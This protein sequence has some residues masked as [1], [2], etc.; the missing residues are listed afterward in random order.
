[1]FERLSV[2]AS[3]IRALFLK[4]SLDRDFNEELQSHLAMLIDENLRRGLSPPE[5]RRQALL[6]LGGPSQIEEANREQRGLPQIDT[7]LQDLRYGLRTLAANRAFTVVAVATLALGIG[8]NTMI[9]SVVNAVFLKPPPYRDPDRLVNVWQT[10]ARHPGERS[11][12]SAPN[13]LDWR[14][15]NHVFESM[16]MFDSAGRGYNLSGEKEPERVYGL[17]VTA[18]LFPLLG[19][20]PFLGRTFLPEEEIRGRDRVVVLAYGLWLRRYGADRSLVGKTIRVDGEP[21]TVVGVMPP[22]FEFDFFSE[23]N[24]LW[25]PVGLDSGDRQRGAHSFGACA[26]LKPGVSLAQ[27]RAE[28]DTIGHRLAR[29]FPQDNG[30]GSVGVTPMYELGVN[31]LR[32]TFTVLFTV[33]GFV[34]LIA[35]VNVANLTLAR[36][37]ARQ[38]ELAIRRALG[39]GRLRIVRQLL[40][41]SLLLALIGGTAGLA[42]ASGGIRLLERVL[43]DDLRYIPFRHLDRISMDGGVFVFTLLVCCITGILFGLASAISALRTGVNEPLKDGASRAS[44]DRLGD[45]L[46]HVL[47]ASEVTLALIV[48]AGAGLL[49]DSMIR[50]LGI[51]PGLDPK[52]VLTMSVSLP[53]TVLYYSPPVRADFCRELSTRAGAIPGVLSVSSI[54]HLPLSGSGAGRGFVIEGRPDPGV[55]DEPGAGYSVTCPAYLKTM[56]IPLLAGREFNDQDTVGA[57]GVIIINQAMARRDWPKENPIGKRIKL[58]HYSS[59]APWLTVVGVAGDVRHFGL[60]EEIRPWFCRPYTQAAWPFMSIVVRTASAPLSF[61]RPVA[62]ALAEFDP[63]QAASSVQTMEEVVR[64]SLGPRRLPMFLLA[65]FGLLA[66]ILAAVGISGV[67]GYSVTQRTQEIGIRMALGARTRDVLRF[68][69]GRS[70]LWTL[71]G[72]AAGIAGS[73]VLTRLM[74]RLLFGVRQADPLVLASV[75]LLLTAVALLASYLPARRATKVDPIIAL[76]CE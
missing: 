28:M 68:T 33:V 31:D 18:S 17:R 74:E 41:E 24:E 66:L 72:V 20:P 50:V 12:I 65:C 15:Q 4:R 60:D 40:T 9:F 54:A 26:R 71:G 22:Q 67:V 29:Q 55:A 32:P 64:K 34:L 8:A 7:L 27:A 42:I 30:D 6:R 70:M 5:A 11:I 73:L 21:R 61:A 16:A 35:C 58:G 59:N 13:F 19:I 10:W 52:N 49:I 1:M 44:T 25:V 69:V 38:R 48:L 76:R 53:Q 3:R 14:S 39:A 56:G 62:R 2:I 51:Q 36:G 37:A 57:P 43:P 75:S 63:D 46:R 45:R 47:A 23:R